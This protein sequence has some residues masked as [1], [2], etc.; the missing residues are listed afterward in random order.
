MSNPLL[1][2]N[3]RMR[4]SVD[5]RGWDE[6]QRQRGQE[7]EKPRVTAKSRVELSFSSGVVFAIAFN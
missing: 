2:L 4:L 1:A 6:T 5:F 7:E 3:W